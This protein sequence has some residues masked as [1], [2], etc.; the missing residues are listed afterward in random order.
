M[1]MNRHLLKEDIQIFISYEEMLKIISHWEMQIKSP[2]RNHFTHNR[3]P[4]IKKQKKKI[5][6]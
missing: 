1:D 3:K 5:M 4:M 6:S 2:M